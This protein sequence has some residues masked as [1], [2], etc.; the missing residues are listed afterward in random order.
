MNTPSTDRKIVVHFV[1]PPIPIRSHD[2]L[3][4]FADEDAES[5]N[6]GYGET[7]QAAIEDLLERQE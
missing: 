4:M 3:A 2:W 6:Y 7:K 5:Q 1:Y